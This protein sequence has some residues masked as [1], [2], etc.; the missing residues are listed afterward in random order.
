M[1]RARRGPF[2]S[3]ASCA[4][5][6][7]H[8]SGVRSVARLGLTH[9]AAKEETSVLRA[10]PTCMQDEERTPI[11]QDTKKGKLRFYPYN[12]KCAPA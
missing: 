5:L 4:A 2:W 3:T 8:L 12:I 10:S 7:G 6:G 11:K 9:G 1:L